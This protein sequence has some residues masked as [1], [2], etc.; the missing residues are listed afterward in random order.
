MRHFLMLALV[1]LC[2]CRTTTPLSADA[3]PPGVEIERLRVENERLRGLLAAESQAA[4]P[5]AADQRRGETVEVLLADVFFESGS[6]ALTPDGRARL[7]NLA[8]RLQRDYAGRTVRIEGH[9]DTQPIGPSLQARFPTN[10]DLSTGRAVAVVR[11]LQDRHNMP[12]G[13]M[14]AV[15]FGAYE[16]VD[17]N[18][19]A[20]GRARNRRVRVA[21]LP[22]N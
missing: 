22:L 6:A 8:A 13:R 7:D 5:P 20:E 16:P 21:V 15:G 11:Y 2:G 19:T 17:S 1:L 18:A 12:P 14:E 9:T 10:W 3:P 4:C